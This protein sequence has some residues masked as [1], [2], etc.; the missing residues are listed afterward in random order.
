[1]EFKDFKNGNKFDPANYRPVSLTC[2]S[3][4]ILEHIVHSH[5]MKH[6]EKFNILSDV[7]HGFRAK[8]STETQLILTIHDKAKAINGNKSVHAVVL[9]FAKAF[10]KVLHQRLL[11][12]LWYYGIHGS[13]FN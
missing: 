12:K 1:M 13:L 10:D 4:K 7:Q 5:V 6:L 2:I 11:Q 3:C 9:D 8:R